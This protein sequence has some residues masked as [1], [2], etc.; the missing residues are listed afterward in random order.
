[1]T[2]APPRA[3]TKRGVERVLQQMTMETTVQRSPRAEYIAKT[4]TGIDVDPHGR[5]VQLELTSQQI[6]PAHAT[7]SLGVNATVSVT[8][9]VSVTSGGKQFKKSIKKKTVRDPKLT[10][11]PNINPAHVNRLV[12]EEAED[13]EN[14]LRMVPPDLVS[15]SVDKYPLKKKLQNLRLNSESIALLEQSVI[16]PAPTADEIETE[17]PPE[18]MAS[19][20]H[21]VEKGATPDSAPNQIFNSLFP[22]VQDRRIDVSS[23]APGPLQ[24]MVVPTTAAQQMTDEVL[25]EEM[26]RSVLE[27][28]NTQELPA[29]DICTQ[30]N[31]TAPMHTSTAEHK[32]P[33]LLDEEIP[34]WENANVQKISMLVGGDPIEILDATDVSILETSKDLSMELSK[35]IDY[36]I[37]ANTVPYETRV[38]IRG[39]KLPEWFPGYMS[40]FPHLPELVKISR[41]PSGVLHSAWK[42]VQP[43]IFPEESLLIV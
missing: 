2:I 42:A 38:Q 18:V 26:E 24:D 4:L 32:I 21:A 9:S 16:Y 6:D 14:T 29:D 20:I 23:V 12:K 10:K 3:K 31:I 19:V 30:N 36:F 34:P 1:M 39:S 33:M 35:G 7:E 15:T 25:T 41:S 13:V 40:A 11:K 28:Q 43:K 5:A 8:S 17:A 27:I 22:D 37:D